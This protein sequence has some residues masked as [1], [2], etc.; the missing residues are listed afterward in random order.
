MEIYFNPYPA[1]AQDRKQALAL[2]IKTSDAFHKLHGQI[3]NVIA[4]EN[5]TLRSFVLFHEGNSGRYFEDA[6]RLAEKKDKEKLVLLMMA[7]SR[8]TVAKLSFGDD[9]NWVVRYLGGGGPDPGLCGEKGGCRIN[10]PDIPWLGY[11][12]HKV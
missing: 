3:K 2:A 9:D 6:F 11:G 12:L 4:E 5:H 1:P 10:N 7:F 8:G